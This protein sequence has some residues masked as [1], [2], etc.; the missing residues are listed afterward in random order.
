M[1]TLLP[2]DQDF[3][4]VRWA[5]KARLHTASY[6]YHPLLY[7]YVK[8]GELM[9]TNSK[10]GHIVT[11]QNKLEDGLYEVVKCTKQ[12]ISLHRFLVPPGPR[13][14]KYP[15]FKTVLPLNEIASCRFLANDRDSAMVGIIAAI[16][17]HG[18]DCDY[19]TDV[20]DFDGDDSLEIFIYGDTQPILFRTA[21]RFAYIMPKRFKLTY[22]DPNQE[23]V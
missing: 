17:T 7:L 21:T 5:I 9:A 22:L 18:I 11:L 15:L 3:A 13:S 23:I 19:V 6:D 10:R 20:F 14:I 12:V 1:L 16:K 8:D 4:H 2:N